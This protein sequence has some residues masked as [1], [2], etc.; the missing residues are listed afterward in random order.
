MPDLPSTQEIARLARS[1]VALLNQL[2]DLSPTDLEEPVAD[3]AAEPAV[4]AAIDGAFPADPGALATPTPSEQNGTPAGTVPSDLPPVIEHPAVVN[5]SP[6]ETSA[7][8]EPGQWLPGVVQVPD[9]PG[10]N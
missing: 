2:A 10:M 1:P 9:D 7:A 8:P 3:P 5:P 4:P 6:A